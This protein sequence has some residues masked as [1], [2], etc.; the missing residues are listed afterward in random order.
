MSLQKLKE[1][2]AKTEH[3]AYGI[4]ANVNC[5]IKIFDLSYDLD[6]ESLVKNIYS[7]RE[8]FP[9]SMH[10]Y[11]SKHTNV[12]A[13]HSDYGTPTYTNIL[14]DLIDVTKQKI[15]PFILPNEKLSVSEMW[16]NIYQPGDRVARHTHHN[17]NGLSTVYFP[18]VDN[19]S[20]PIIFD[21]NF[22]KKE[23]ITITPKNG[24]LIVFPSL[25]FHRVPVVKEQ[26]RIS[27]SSN[28]NVYRDV[29]VT[30]EFLKLDNT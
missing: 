23:E 6:N 24:M 17:Y 7:F 22:E 11:K 19:D 30:K 3:T 9:Q 26:H 13:W 10:E 16:I 5:S 12:H 14:D 1:K 28:L 2:I 15:K 18:Y 21:N 8:K 4:N 20:T 29:K 27:I 25:I